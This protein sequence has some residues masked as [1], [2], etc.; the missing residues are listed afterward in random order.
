MRKADEP[1]IRLR[2]EDAVTDDRQPL[3]PRGHGAFV[4]G[5]AELVEE[6][7]D[8]RRILQSCVPDRQI[9]GSRLRSRAR[10][11]LDRDRHAVRA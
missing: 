4:R 6:P 7:G 1:T 10:R 5:I 8:V 2:D 11:G 3:Q 9:H